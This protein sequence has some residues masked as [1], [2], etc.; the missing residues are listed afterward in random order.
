MKSAKFLAFKRERIRK[1][2]WFKI[3]KITIFG[4][5]LSI[6]MHPQS[7]ILNGNIVKQVQ[8]WSIL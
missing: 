5:C 1:K 7:D 2:C 4:V 8:H 6:Q 3:I